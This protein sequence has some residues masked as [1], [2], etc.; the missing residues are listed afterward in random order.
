MSLLRANFT[1]GLGREREFLTQL[2]PTAKRTPGF[3]KRSPPPQCW[4]LTGIAIKGR[5][6]GDTGFVLQAGPAKRGRAASEGRNQVKPIRNLPEGST[7]V[8]GRRQADNS[9]KLPAFPVTKKIPR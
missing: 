9:E 3:E 5:G 2:C 6:G 7:Y 8:R 4:H 1:A